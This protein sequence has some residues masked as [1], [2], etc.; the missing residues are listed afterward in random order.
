MKRC[1]IQTEDS[2][3]RRL[4]CFLFVLSHAAPALGFSG[5]DDDCGC[6]GQSVVLN[7]ET[8]DALELWESQQVWDRPTL[9]A[10]N[11][12]AIIRS[13]FGD[14]TSQRVLLDPL[15]EANA[16]RENLNL[17]EEIITHS[18]STA[19][20]DTLTIEEKI[21]RIG[22]EHMGNHDKK[23]TMCRQIS[24]PDSIGGKSFI[25][26]L[27]FKRISFEQVFRLLRCPIRSSDYNLCKKPDAEEPDPS[28]TPTCGD[29]FLMA[30]INPATARTFVY[31]MDSFKELDREARF[32]PQVLQ[33]K[34]KVKFYYEE[35]GVSKT[36][37]LTFR[38]WIK[39]R[40]VF[41]IHRY[42]RDTDS[43]RAFH[44]L[45]YAIYHQGSPFHLQP[46]ESP[47]SRAF[48]EQYTTLSCQEDLPE[49]NAW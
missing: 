46:D 4:L 6:S 39:N 22:I 2:T 12:S 1:R 37:C 11:V 36:R 38:E 16:M 47:P 45:Y 49:R 26:T 28:G 17:F 25:R 18:I 10:S 43:Q 19:S 7:D 14:F 13:D 9:L 34:R 21:R 48:C 20:S 27:R 32:L 33:C 40:E 8:R 30:A 23:D 44:E 41:F 5:F 42:P 31:I 24:D 29:I 15:R 35:T 3:M